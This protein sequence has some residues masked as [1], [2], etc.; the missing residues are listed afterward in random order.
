M[1]MKCGQ[2]KN[3]RAE[4]FRVFHVAGLDETKPPFAPC[5][6]TELKSLD[7]RMLFLGRGHSRSYETNDFPG[8]LSGIYFLDDNGSNQ[9][10][11]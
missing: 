5:L 4:Y 8:F 2:Q 9:G 1:V 10:G 7:G 3:C 6:C 11:V